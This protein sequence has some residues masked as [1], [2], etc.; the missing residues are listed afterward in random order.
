[1]PG[2]YP[3]R[4]AEN[5]LRDWVKWAHDRNKP[6]LLSELGT[7]LF[8]WGNEDTGPSSYEAGLKDAGLVVRGLNAGVDGFN[9]WS[10]TNRRD[11]D[12]QWQLVDTWDID[13]GRLLAEFRPRP[14]AYYLYGLLSRFSAKYS[15]VAEVTVNAPFGPTERKP[16]AAALFSPKGNLTLFIVNES[17]RPTRVEFDVAGL[18]V[19]AKFHRYAVTA[20]DRDEAQVTVAPPGEFAVAAVSAKFDD[21][22]P[23]TSLLVY[24]GFRLRH[25]EPGVASE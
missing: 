10:F 23:A 22:V 7:M 16:V 12:G 13:A 2:G 21:L 18:S 24:S 11:L 6:F 20:A 1:M 5:R 15:K 9:R 8:G 25:D 4:E 3:L 17:H 19:A 14:N